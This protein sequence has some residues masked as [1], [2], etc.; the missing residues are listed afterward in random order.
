MITLAEMKVG[1]QDKVA[2]KVVDIF[3]RESQLLEMLPFDNAV[4]PTGGSTLTYNYLQKKRLQQLHSV[5]LARNTQLI[6]RHLRR[7]QL[8]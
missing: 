5:L 2:E 8:T 3:I 1:M 4:S 6:R 7:S